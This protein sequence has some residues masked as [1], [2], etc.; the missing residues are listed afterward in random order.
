M[1]LD[2]T[3]WTAE[4]DALLTMLDPYWPYMAAAISIGLA[5]TVTVHVAQNK[6]DARAA[7]AWTGLVWLVPVLGALLYYILG[8][9]RIRRR[10]RQLTGGLIDSNDGWRVAA[11][12][13]PDLKHLKILSR[14]VGRLTHLPLTDGNRITLLDAPGAYQAMLDAIDNANERDRK[15]VV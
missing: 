11:E 10:A 3:Y 2:V 7:A 14:L 12:P 8:V 15:S 13:E 9:N 4:I 5:V 6:R 1:P